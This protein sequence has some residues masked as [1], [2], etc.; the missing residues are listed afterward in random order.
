MLMFLYAAGN[1]PKVGRC[2]CLST[3]VCI[4]GIRRRRW[5]RFVARVQSD[6]ISHIDM[7]DDHIDTVISHIIS[8]YPI[9][10]SRMTV[11]IL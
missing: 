4:H 3:W 1:Y 9:S 5:V 2:R 7:E 10:I 8:P 11:S 6:K